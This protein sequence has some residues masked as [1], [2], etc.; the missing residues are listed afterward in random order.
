VRFC[1]VN[2]AFESATTI[3]ASTSDSNFPVS[4]LTSPFRSKR[5]RSTSD[6]S[7]WVVFDLATTED[8]NSIVIL[9]P[10]EDGIRLSNSVTLKIQANATNV[11]TSPSVDQALTIDNTYMCASHF[12]STD[13]SYRY[14]RVSISDAGNPYGYVELGTVWIGKS[15]TLDPPENGFKFAVADTSRT[16]KTDFG[17]EYVDEYPLLTSVEFS[18]AYMSYSD[19]QTLENAYRTNG[20]RSPVLVAFDE[21]GTVFD[22]DHFLIY[23]KMTKPMGLEHASYN[24]FN[25]G[26]AVEEL[27]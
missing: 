4:N 11:W 25:S 26:V 1:N 23:G 16:Q 3:T 22:K 9:W 2:Y 7:Q 27:A 14:W 8:I 18:Y 21:A 15:I 13:Q 10:R 24:L 6:T 5:W 17:H 12:F 20:R 19:A